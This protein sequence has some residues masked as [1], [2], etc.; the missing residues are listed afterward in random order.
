MRKQ[1]LNEDVFEAS[2]LCFFIVS[3]N[4]C[5]DEYLLWFFLHFLLKFKPFDEFFP[6]K[7]WLQVSLSQ[8]VATVCVCVSVCVH[9]LNKDVSQGIIGTFLQCVLQEMVRW[10]AL[11]FV[12]TLCWGL[13]CLK[14]DDQC[15]FLSCCNSCSAC[16]V[17]FLTGK[18]CPGKYAHCR[19]PRPKK[20]LYTYIFTRTVRKA[21]N[22]ISDKMK[23]SFALLVLRTRIEKCTAC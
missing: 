21:L 18:G 20:F 19:S 4:R 2:A 1:R 15:F 13:N 16:E 10:V 23:L 22:A 8:C 5:Y 7:T 9:P 11:R 14:C 6:S 3:F 17:S 12:I